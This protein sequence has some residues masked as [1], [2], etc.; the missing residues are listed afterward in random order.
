[1]SEFSPAFPQKSKQIRACQSV[2]VSKTSRSTISAQLQ[3]DHS[4]EGPPE[5][6]SP[7]LRNHLH[8]LAMQSLPGPQN[9]IGDLWAAPI[10]YKPNIL[11]VQIRKSPARL[12]NHQRHRHN[13]PDLTVQI[14][15]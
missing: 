5:P 11:P 3:P 8:E 9:F 2:A 10:H 15:A 4:R 6:S 7:R 12:R 1:M 13:I 14:Q